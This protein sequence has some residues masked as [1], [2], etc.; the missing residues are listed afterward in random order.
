LP[1]E[2]SVFVLFTKTSPIEVFSTSA[3]VEGC[4][5]GNVPGEGSIPDPPAVFHTQ[6][7]DQVQS[8]QVLNW[9]RTHKD[10]F[11]GEWQQIIS[12]MLANPERSSSD[13][14]RELQRLSPGRYPPLQI[15]TLQRGMRKIR[16]YLLETFEDG[17]QD[18][19]IRGP[20]H[21]PVSARCS[22]RIS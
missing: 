13:I 3:S 7:Q 10:P 4:T 1:H 18:E 2:K 8:K 12:W 20:L 15:R 22:T 11:A 21:S 9:R 6:Y 16:A 14:F 5:T 17:W 19:V